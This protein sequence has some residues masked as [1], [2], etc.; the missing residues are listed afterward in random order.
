MQRVHIRGITFLVMSR[1]APELPALVLSVGFHSALFLA[2]FQARPVLEQRATPTPVPELTPVAT[3]LLEESPTLIKP[4]LPAIQPPTPISQPAPV[5]TPVPKPSTALA[6]KPALR[7]D[8]RPVLAPQT[9]PE[10]SKATPTPAPA[11]AQA[12]TPTPAPKADTPEPKEE[13]IEE[14]EEG[15]TQGDKLAEVSSTWLQFVLSEQK[16]GVLSDPTGGFISDRNRWV[17]DQS[18][19]RTNTHRALGDGLSESELL[20]PVVDRKGKADDTSVGLKKGGRARRS[21]GGGSPEITPP[22]LP[23]PITPDRVLLPAWPGDLLAGATGLSILLERPRPV[24]KTLPRRIV[25]VQAPKA[26]PQEQ[27]SP[28][29]ALAPPAPVQKG[30]DDGF[31]T[32]LGED[33]PELLADEDGDAPAP[34]HTAAWSGREVV[35]GGIVLGDKTDLSLQSHELGS[36]IG[37]LVNTI[38]AAWSYPP[39]L[40]ALGVTGKV[41]IEFTVEPNGSVSNKSVVAGQEMPELVIAAMDAIPDQ[42]EPVPDRKRWRKGIRFRYTFHYGDT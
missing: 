14:P 31:W 25:P 35:T 21:A 13:L 36:W 16:G 1:P 7:P 5:P 8:Y 32:A 15:G 23:V 9:P 24:V 22:S 34:D 38:A 2:F 29:P 20:Q 10:A 17:L 11:L 4:D 40:R 28:L 27:P 26:P 19:T 18:V 39:E 3:T 37:T 12:P 42:V 6:E 30:S 41:T 33:I